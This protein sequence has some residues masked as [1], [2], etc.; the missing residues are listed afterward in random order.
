MVYLSKPVLNILSSGFP[1]GRHSAARVG[2]EYSMQA[3]AISARV[4]GSTRLP[5]MKLR[6]TCGKGQRAVDRAW[7]SSSCRAARPGCP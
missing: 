3:Q 2:T 6:L 7:P 5:P 4:P 1:A